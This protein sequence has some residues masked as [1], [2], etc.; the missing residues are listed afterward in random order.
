MASRIVSCS[1]P[2]IHCA[3]Q[4]RSCGTLSL[5]RACQPAIASRRYIQTTNA[6]TSQSLF[7]IDPSVPDLPYETDLLSIDGSD[8]TEPEQCRPDSTPHIQIETASRLVQMETVQSQA[9]VNRIGSDASKVID[10]QSNESHLQTMEDNEI[11]RPRRDESSLVFN[12]QA[13]PLAHMDF[14]DQSVDLHSS[15]AAEPSLD[16]VFSDFALKL[17]SATS[18]MQFYRL[19]KTHLNSPQIN[20]WTVDDF[21]A[22]LTTLSQQYDKLSLTQREVDIVLSRI[23]TQSPQ[24]DE[25]KQQRIRTALALYTLAMRCTALQHV[26][27]QQHKLHQQQTT[28]RLHPELIQKVTSILRACGKRFVAQRIEKLDEAQVKFMN[29]HGQ[30]IDCFAEHAQN[31]SVPHSKVENEHMLLASA[32]RLQALSSHEAQ[33][34]AVQSEM[35]L[36]QLNLLD[37][38]PIDS[39][40]STVAHVSKRTVELLLHAAHT[41]S[42]IDVSVCCGLS[43]EFEAMIRRVQESNTDSTQR[44]KRYVHETL[45]V[46]LI[47]RTIESRG[48]DITARLDTSYYDALMQLHAT[49]RD[50]RAA[51][52]VKRQI[53]QQQQDRLQQQT[54]LKRLARRS[55][56]LLVAPVAFDLLHYKCVFRAMCYA[57]PW[58]FTPA[59]LQQAIDLL[60]QLKAV[61]PLRSIHESLPTPTH[62]ADAAKTSGDQPF[63][64]VDT[65][66]FNDCIRMAYQCQDSET[67]MRLYQDM[68][69]YVDETNRVT[70]HWLA[71]S[72]IESGQDAQL[73]HA[74]FGTK[75]DL[76]QEF[77]A[78]IEEEQEMMQQIS[79]E[80][81]PMDDAPDL[82]NESSQGP[83]PTRMQTLHK[84]LDQLKSQQQAILNADRQ[85]IDAQAAH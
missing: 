4:L 60:D 81:M 75:Q 72:H 25:A 29:K 63:L 35:L 17:K 73:L 47:M 39:E 51:L 2:L 66:C 52:N 67:A 34:L 48:A 46:P 56:K 7:D 28:Q 13:D 83:S 16:D 23:A 3:R 20:E 77:E 71:R 64:R 61:T 9:D 74:L 43:S 82:D 57:Q 44:A 70:F 84:R 33:K 31:H 41:L 55:N 58:E 12:P 26:L 5:S 10:I 21:T 69:L 53:E 50:W 40:L 54:V 76:K 14:S 36:S 24:I 49:T 18:M 45:V 15:V 85:K 38:P 8:D 37:S 30:S 19:L 62:T 65:S 59:L 11:D 27:A 32:E 79:E 42:G 80:D 68:P 78:M 1:L 22:L 6:K